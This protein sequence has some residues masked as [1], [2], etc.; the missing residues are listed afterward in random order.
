[1]KCCT[2]VYSATESTI[3]NKCH[4]LLV[5]NGFEDLLKSF[6]FPSDLIFAFFEKV[7]WIGMF[8]LF[9][10]S[11]IARKM[12]NPLKRNNAGGK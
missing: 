9:I 5:L 6:F 7:Q 11:V 10:Y 12:K 4:A 2:K 8:A 3:A 1:M